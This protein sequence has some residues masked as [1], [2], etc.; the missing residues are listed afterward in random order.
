MTAAAPDAVAAASD[1]FPESVRK[2]IAGIEEKPVQRRDAP[3]HAPSR[4]DA[5]AR[6]QRLVHASRLTA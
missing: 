5:L 1:D 4:A 2:F 3:S 6:L